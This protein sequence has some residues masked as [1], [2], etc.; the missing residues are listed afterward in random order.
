MQLLIIIKSP[1]QT[2]WTW[3]CHITKPQSFEHFNKLILDNE[4]NP[5]S[6]TCSSAVNLVKDLTFCSKHN[7]CFFLLCVVV[8][9]LLKSS[10][11][12][13]FINLIE[14]FQFIVIDY[15]LECN[16]EAESQL[17]INH[18]WSHSSS[19][20]C[21]PHQS[22]IITLTA[23]LHNWL[24]SLFLLLPTHCKHKDLKE[25]PQLRKARW[26]APSH[27]VETPSHRDITWKIKLES[28]FSYE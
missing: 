9:T 13:S 1:C 16:V 15:D 24:Y 21:V 19:L 14:K 7:I 3:N 2:I 26:K 12:L 8:C 11:L 18:P 4:I 28:M 25:A 27:N 17:F 5:P 6:V 23:P 10:N 22:C 20:H